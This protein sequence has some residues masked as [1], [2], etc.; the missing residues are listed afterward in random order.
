MCKGFHCYTPSW[1]ETPDPSSLTSDA[2]LDLGL[3]PFPDRVARLAFD[4]HYHEV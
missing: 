2:T 4:M 1:A 3:S